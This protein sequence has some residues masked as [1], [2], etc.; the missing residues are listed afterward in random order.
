MLSIEE[1]ITYDS[2]GT[3]EIKKYNYLVSLR[4]GN[5]E[6]ERSVPDIL[7]QTAENL[8]RQTPHVI[9]EEGCYH[10]PHGE[11]THKYL[12]M[13]PILINQ[14]IINKF[15]RYL[16]NSLAFY[17][18]TKDLDVDIIVGGTH[19]AK[20][21]INM[22]GQELSAKTLTID[23][24]VGQIDEYTIGET[25]ANKKALIVSDVISSGNFVSKIANRLTK[26]GSSIIAICSICDLRTS[27]EKDSL[28][29]NYPVIS[30]LNYPITK[31]RIPDRTPIFEV[32]PIS[33]RPTLPE[34]EVKRREVHSLIPTEIL[35]QWVND[36][37][38]L[39]P[40]H[41]IL[42]PTHY[43]YFVD[44]EILLE[45]YS[46]EIFEIVNK[47][48]IK[49][50][51]NNKFNIANELSTII[52]AEG[53]NAELYFPEL[54]KKNY[55]WIEWIQIDR[56]RL[57]IEGTWQLDRL[58]P[59]FDPVEK[60]NDQ[61]VLIWD[62]GSNT[63]GTL[64]QLLEIVSEFKPKLIIAYCMVNRLSSER[65]R[66]FSRLNEIGGEQGAIVRFFTNVPMS[67]F[68]QSNCPICNRNL[69][70]IPPIDEVEKYHSLKIRMFRKHRWNHI[71]APTINEISRK[72]MELRE[73]GNIDLFLS[74]VFKI[75][76]MLGVFENNVYI[77]QEERASIIKFLENNL[78]IASLCYI[79]NWEPQ[80]L[81]SVM[82]FQLP[83]FVEDLLQ[84]ILKLLNHSSPEDIVGTHDILEFVSNREP[85]FIFENI[86]SFLKLLTIEKK[87]CIILIYNIISQNELSKA[88]ELLLTLSDT[89]DHIPK[90]LEIRSYLRGLCN[91]ALGSI[92]IKITQNIE[93]TLRSS[94][95]NLQQF[96]RISGKPHGEAFDVGQPLNRILNY[97]DFFKKSGQ[98]RE[99]DHFNS[100]Y[101]DWRDYTVRAL[102]GRLAFD[103]KH[104][105]KILELELSPS[106]NKYYMF[107]GKSE[108][109]K[110]Y[111]QL[112]MLLSEL[113][114][115]ND[116][117]SLL[118]S[119]F[120][121]VERRAR[122]LHERL[123]DVNKSPIA[124]VVNKMPVFVVKHISQ[125]IASHLPW[126]KAAG[127]KTN[128][129]IPFR[130]IN[131]FMTSRIFKQ[132]IDRTF[133]NIKNHNFR[134]EGAVSEPI[135]QDFLLAI[136]V[137]LDQTDI[138]IKIKSNGPHSYDNIPSHGIR[139][140]QSDSIIF[141]GL[142]DIYNQDEWVVN[143]IK[144]RRW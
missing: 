106:L 89:I 5:Y 13:K 114:E 109:K 90:D 116:Q 26:E 68:V 105:K 64:L 81:D 20:R 35:V 137:E 16:I 25:V 57:S 12:Y 79:F 139:I 33:L 112:Q 134:I 38:A 104:I 71:S 18:R 92:N 120:N 141:D 6:V 45:K 29:L 143:L 36:S 80:L 9:N 59:I 62:D 127:I 52:T 11:Y 14:R 34:D 95:N 124:Q 56:I 131:G 61:V 115:S 73:V 133:I 51:D 15:A 54:I 96:Y 46:E 47:D 40:G 76:C 24:Y 17:L 102:E 39:V 3:E 85:Q 63:G 123:F 28:P 23:R 82:N 100:I 44:T 119:N 74:E 135:Y 129:D 108:L 69:H 66:F 94:I 101:R 37:K 72:N 126:I 53:S 32:N 21:L 107:E 132:I 2:D 4:M 78:S 122:R 77:T 125:R 140:N 31:M 65:S 87:Q 111:L 41:T 86:N 121:E 136:N 91:S 42:G 55:P 10:L 97:I 84:A 138:I 43:T 99:G 93:D 27:I 58:D 83:G 19:S 98:V 103:L 49:L 67:T 70:E 88:H 118:N 117:K 130:E 22:V 75:R 30:L 144:L 128:I 113:R 60:I 7:K 110:D 8:I 48:L 1:Y 142:F 50:A